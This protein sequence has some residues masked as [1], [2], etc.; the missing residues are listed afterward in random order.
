MQ[1]I[2][3]PV[4]KK[5]ISCVLYPPS[6]QSGPNWS[7]RI[8]CAED[9]ASAW[10]R[11][12][13]KKFGGKMIALDWDGKLDLDV[14]WLANPCYDIHEVAAYIESAYRPVPS[15]FASGMDE[16]PVTTDSD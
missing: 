7:M 5:A 9:A 14:T 8:W 12:E 4:A 6:F 11:E 3:I 10:V 15:A 13:L 16:P 2:K 1:E